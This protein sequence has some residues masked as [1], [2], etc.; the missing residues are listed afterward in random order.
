MR[1][2]AQVGSG[3]SRDRLRQKLRT[4]T[5]RFLNQ[6]SATGFQH[7]ARPDLAV[8]ENSRTLVTPMSCVHGNQSP[9]M[10]PASIDALLVLAHVR[11]SVPEARGES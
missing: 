5:I 7:G 2:R 11:A 9:T 8:V 4:T 3:A 10:N 1:S 6:L